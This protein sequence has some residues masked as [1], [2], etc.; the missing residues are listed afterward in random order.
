[1]ERSSTTGFLILS[2]SAFTRPSRQT[3]L[4]FN[5]AKVLIAAQKG[6]ET[7][8]GFPV[9]RMISWYNHTIPEF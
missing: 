9:F 2:A 7:S 4:V 5:I 8:T 3:I 6:L 1:M